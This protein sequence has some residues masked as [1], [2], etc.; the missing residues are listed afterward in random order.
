[1]SRLFFSN[2]SR[3]WST[4]KKPLLFK[5]LIVL[6][7]LI[8]IAVLSQS[9]AKGNIRPFLIVV[10]ILGAFFLV[11][12]IKLPYISFIVL[13]GASLFVPFGIGTGSESSFNISLL[14]VGLMAG[15]MFI[16]MFIN[17]SHLHVKIPRSIVAII[18]LIV[19]TI[20]SFGFG[21]LPYFAANLAPI[22]AQ[23]GAVALF[24]FSGLIF[25]EMCYQIQK[26]E[27]LKWITW[28][29]L[30][31]GALAI[32]SRFVPQLSRFNIDSAQGSQFWTWILAIAFSQ[33][34]INKKLPLFWRS[35]IGFLAFIIFYVGFV[36][37]RDW[38][39]GWLPGLIAILVIFLLFAKKFRI[40]FI[41]IASIG[42]LFN[43]QFVN[44]VFMGGDNPYS[45][46]TRLQAWKILEEIIKVN[47]IFGV[48][49][50]NYYWY[51]PLFQILGYSVKFNSHNNYV[52]IIAQ[53]GLVG[54]ASFGWV[55]FEI[56]RLGFRLN[57]VIQDG[58]EKAYVL[59]A[60]GGL[61]GTVASG[62]LGDWIIPFVYNV[63]FNG[64]RASLLAWLF[65]GGLVSI[66][67]INRR[68]NPL[69]SLN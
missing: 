5:G 40:P 18:V 19:S 13:I 3:I 69:P 44:Q 22:R 14:L 64:F 12:L 30:A 46:M 26:L 51:T 41:V 54:L 55:I 67:R 47:P 23:I 33:V 49:P 16:D 20:I 66:E 43:V 45:L 37:T 4:P 35:A 65:L 48:G 57:R 9:V 39:S 25:I 2:L 63:G 31:F 60:L 61:V 68:Q 8:V 34:L 27:W 62:M 29:F 21:Q 17:R 36:Q 11:L 10:G 15:L 42:L 53:T 38:I 58:F 32:I 1:M 28:S 6:I 7:T 50:A 24:V 56:G 52:D 59:G